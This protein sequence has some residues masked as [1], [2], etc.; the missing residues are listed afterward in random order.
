MEVK[1]LFVDTNETDDDDGGGGDGGNE[2][3]NDDDGCEAEITD[4][5]DDE[6]D[7]GVALVGRGGEEDLVTDVL[8]SL[9]EV[10][11]AVEE[12][13]V[14]ADDTGGGVE[15]D[16]VVGLVEGEM[17]LEIRLSK[18]EPYFIYLFI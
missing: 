15:M 1:G 5:D 6:D 13:G 4:E 7:D 3:G 17:E 10:L 16:V 14:V 8:R 18:S 11:G 2:D 12:N 9:E